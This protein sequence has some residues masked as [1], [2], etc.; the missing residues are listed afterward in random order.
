M[1]VSRDGLCHDFGFFQCGFVTHV[2]LDRF[3]RLVVEQVQGLGTGHL[4]QHRHG[5]GIGLTVVV[6]VDVHTVHHIEVRVG[7][8][9]FHGGVFY[10]GRDASGHEAREIRFRGELLRVGQRGRGTSCGFVGLGR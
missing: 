9:L 8:Q 5:Q 7:E 10:I 3:F 1:V 2:G 4:T 6:D